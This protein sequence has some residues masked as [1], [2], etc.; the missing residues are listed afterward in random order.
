M[1]KNKN[2]E[3]RAEELILVYQTEYSK[4]KM[5]LDN[6]ITEADADH[7]LPKDRTGRFLRPSNLKDI[8]GQSSTV[9]REATIKYEI[10]APYDDKG[11]QDDDKG[12]QDDV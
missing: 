10:D 2:H 1:E 8:L 5:L 7:V 9:V 4:L 12:Y 6:I 11:Y 3:V